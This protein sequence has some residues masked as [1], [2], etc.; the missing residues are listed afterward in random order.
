MGNGYINWAYSYNRIF[1]LK[2]IFENKLMQETV[3]SILHGRKPVYKTFVKNA[4]KISPKCKGWLSLE[5][6]F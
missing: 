4:E 5:S 2:I 1:V 3:V 6:V